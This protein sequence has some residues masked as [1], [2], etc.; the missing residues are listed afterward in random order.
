[1]YGQSHMP[2][3]VWYYTC[4]VHAEALML[5]TASHLRPAAS[6]TGAGPGPSCS[7]RMR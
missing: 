2:Y 5:Y 4:R 1:V 3:S 6:A 7:T